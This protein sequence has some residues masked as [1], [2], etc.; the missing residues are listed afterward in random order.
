MWWDH[1]VKAMRLLGF[2]GGPF[3]L[4]DALRLQSCARVYTRPVHFFRV[5]RVCPCLQKPAKNPAQCH[6]LRLSPRA[7][8]SRPAARACIAKGVFAVQGIAEG[9]TI[10]EYVGEVVT[11]EDA[12]FG[13]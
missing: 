12:L 9:E 7:A 13:E 2:T 4:G 1:R 11:W 6:L 3:P 8:V 5:N 10:L